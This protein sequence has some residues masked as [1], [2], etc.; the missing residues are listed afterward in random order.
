MWNLVPSTKHSSN[1]ITHI[2]HV[3]GLNCICKAVKLNV[4]RKRGST[5]CNATDNRGYLATAI[6]E[7]N[8]LKS[9]EL[10]SDD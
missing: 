8:R 5:N 6:S 3:K 1:C 9:E 7:H 10:L 2:G 4:K